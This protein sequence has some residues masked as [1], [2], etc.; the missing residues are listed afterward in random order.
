MPKNT[1]FGRLG[2]RKQRRL[3]GLRTRTR[4]IRMESL[5][6]RHLLAV[7]FLAGDGLL[8]LLN[9]VDLEVGPQRSNT[10]IQIDINQTDPRN[11]VSSNQGSL[12][13]SVNSGGDFGGTR[14][15]DDMLSSGQSSG[16]D[17]DVVFDADGRL[18]WTNLVRVGEARTIGTA[19]RVLPAMC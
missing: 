13:V 3:R 11:V 10:E 6:P 9:R 15:F 8:P 17:P 2:H 14:T 18:F 5:E 7:Q 19:R 1:L 16:G 4:T 12:N